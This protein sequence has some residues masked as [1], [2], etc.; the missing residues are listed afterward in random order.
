MFAYKKERFI[1]STITIFILAASMVGHGSYNYPQ[2]EYAWDEKFIQA[3]KL[4]Q[5]EFCDDS[6]FSQMESL[7]QAKIKEIVIWRKKCSL[8]G[9]LV[10]LI[11]IILLYI[12]QLSYSC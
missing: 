6:S 12:I 8:F 4:A 7:Y 2:L 9:C 1:L 3:Y 10:Y 5:K 11:I